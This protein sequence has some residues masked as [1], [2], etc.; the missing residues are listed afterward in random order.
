MLRGA[1]AKYPCV[2]IK[3]IK[4]LHVR[5]TRKD[6]FQPDGEYRTRIHMVLAQGVALPFESSLINNY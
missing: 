3:R 2:R 4:L 6:G 5:E 1:S